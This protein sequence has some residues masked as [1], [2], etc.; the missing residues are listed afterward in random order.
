MTSNYRNN[1]KT[2][3]AQSPYE[4]SI[5]QLIHLP[6]ECSTEYV[7]HYKKR[8]EA[9]ESG[10]AV[11]FGLP[12]MDRTIIPLLPGDVMGILA[13][14]GHL[15][16]TF[17]GYMAKRTAS[18]IIE[19]GYDNRCVVYVTLEQPVEEIEAYFQSGGK[20]TVSDFAWGR[21]AID[22]IVTGSVKRIGLPIITI[23]RSLE[24]R[25][26]NLPALTVDVIYDSLRSIEKKHKRIPA[27]V[28]IDYIQ[29]IPL[30]RHAD[31]QTEVGEAMVGVKALATDLGAPF[32]IAIQAARKVD[33]YKEKLPHKDDCQHNSLIEQELDKLLSGWRV[34]LTEKKLRGK[35]INVG[36]KVVPVTENLF[37][38]GLLKQRFEKAGYVYHSY[39]DPASMRL[40]D[41]ELPDT[42][43]D[44]DYYEGDTDE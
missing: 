8:K 30:S 40:G 33:G 20:Y 18:K 13:R 21:V 4:L 25:K 2:E 26:R 17:C 31:R 36:G 29:K 16:S 32:L 44:Q 41:L 34:W 22:D 19:A 6:Q 37:V 42:G 5:E 35:D 43:P 38:M 11:T 14:P 9:I 24:R 15:K 7:E 28:I 39:F 23:G 10:R 1:S 3:Q 12:A 27:L